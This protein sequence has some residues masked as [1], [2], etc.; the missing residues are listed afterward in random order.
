MHAKTIVF[1]NLK[2]GCGR[3]TASVLLAGELAERGYKVLVCDCDK[4]QTA[5]AW[6]AAAPDETPFPAA[7]LS[8]ASYGAKVHREIQKQLENYDYI[9]V[10]L[11]PSADTAAAPQSA[12]LV[13]DLAVVVVTPSPAD[14]WASHN[15][16][17]LI[18]DTQA[19]NEE[20]KAVLFVNRTRRTILAKALITELPNLGLPVLVSEFATRTAYQ[21]AVI[22]GS[23]ISALG[24]NAR[25]AI[26]EV[27]ALTDEVLTYLGVPK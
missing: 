27:K 18:E 4:Q 19:I 16:K 5:S 23:T 21:E 1:G 22:R 11:P 9:I 13:A 15:F 2:G 25:V 8:F 7:V 17:K 20:L 26:S 6:A 3:S 10:D 24:R 14:I 12:L